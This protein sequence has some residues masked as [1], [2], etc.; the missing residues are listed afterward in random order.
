M[1]VARG[2]AVSLTRE[3]VRV[4]SRNPS[5][6]A[7]GPG[8]GAVARVLGGVLEAWGLQ[9]EL[10][11]AA[12][13][14]PNVVARVSGADNTGPAGRRSLMFNGHLDVVGIDGMTHAAWGAD[15]RNGR[16][17]GRGASDM[18][19][20]V[21][22]MCAAAARAADASPSIDIVITAIGLSA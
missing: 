16:I 15:A 7:G 9:V 1:P 17:Y 12:P 6:V 4:D 22:A 11:E 13:G 21:A 10:L 18:K 3:L 19:A 2:D 14:R 20:G 5:L 8:E